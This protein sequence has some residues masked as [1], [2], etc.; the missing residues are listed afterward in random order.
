MPT[1]LKLEVNPAFESFLSPRRFKVAYGGRGGGKTHDIAQMLLAMGLRK[2]MLIV[3]CRHI[4]NRI[5]ESVY[6][7]LVNLIDELDLHDDYE[8]KKNQIEGKNGTVFSFRGLYRNHTD[9]KGLE[10]ADI[11]WVEEAESIPRS[12]WEVLIPTIRKKGSEIWV[13]FN[14]DRPDDYTYTYFVEWGKDNDRFTHAFINY[15]DNIYCPQELI[16]EAELLRERDPV[17]YN[18]IYLGIPIINSDALI[19]KGRYEVREFETIANTTFYH[20]AD[21]GDT[22]PTVLVRCFISNG[23]LY[24]DMEAGGSNIDIDKLPAVFRTIPTSTK[25]PIIADSAWP[26]TIRYLQNR[27]FKVQKVKKHKV[28][29]GI[30][31][32]KGFDKIVIHPR[33]KGVVEEFGKY[34]YKVD[35]LSG[36]VTPII[37]DKHNHFID[38]IRYALS[39]VLSQSKRP[40]MRNIPLRVAF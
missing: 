4:Q 38:A 5:E 34:S 3:C 37:V 28:E 26:Q 39:K 2:R 18:N 23:V 29:E 11:C 35:K 33:C 25:W 6:T 20:G 9:I 27:G 31:F 14:P 19:F 13:S 22:D 32:L 16:D 36:E 12:V 24:V 15:T 40:R 17:A 8:I 21:W 10:G 30:K 1:I 7:K